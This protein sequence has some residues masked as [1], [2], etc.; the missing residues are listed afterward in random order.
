MQV[1]HT[2]GHSPGHLSLFFPDEK[3]LFTADLDLVKAGPYYGDKESDIDETIRSLERLMDIDADIYL[4]CHG[5]Y[6]V[7]DGDPA[8]IQKYLDVIYQRENRLLESLAEKPLT[9]EEI[10]NLG[11][12]YGKREVS[13]AWDLSL[14]EKMMMKKHIERLVRAEKVRRD[15]NHYIVC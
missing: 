6:G 7:Y 10:T 13:G 3:V 11:I 12:I 15:V 8:Y 1:L 5:K 2:P 4:S 9:I 14:S